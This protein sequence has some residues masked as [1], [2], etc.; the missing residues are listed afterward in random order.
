VGSP[1][2]LRYPDGVCYGATDIPLPRIMKET[3][4]T[5][6]RTEKTYTVP[7][8]S[9]Q[10]CVIAISDEVGQVP[11]IESVDVELDSKR[12]TVRGSELDDGALRAAIHETGYEA[13]S[14]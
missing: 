10:H 5:P 3:T 13:A 4:V 9:C 14:G 12:V 1:L 7:A 2:I 8:M 6:N 11:G